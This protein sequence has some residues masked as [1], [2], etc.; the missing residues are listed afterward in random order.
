MDATKS[1]MISLSLYSYDG[2]KVKNGPY[3]GFPHPRD[4]KDPSNV[5]AR[6]WIPQTLGDQIWKLYE[7][8]TA[9][10][11]DDFMNS[12][13]DVYAAANFRTPKQAFYDHW[14]D[15]KLSTDADWWE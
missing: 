12:P 8:E 13:P 11:R 3:G 6:A 1:L 7:F 2:S 15:G 9:E 5:T 10:Q 14:V 4:I